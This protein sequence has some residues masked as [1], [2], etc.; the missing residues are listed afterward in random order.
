VLSIGAM[1]SGNGRYYLELAREDYYLEGGEPPGRWWG[2]GAK[3]L[4]LGTR[5]DRDGL[6]GLLKGFSPAEKPLTQNAGR[7][8]HQPGWDLTFSA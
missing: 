2:R 6:G 3:K 5:V 8:R 1:Q 4:D 7:A